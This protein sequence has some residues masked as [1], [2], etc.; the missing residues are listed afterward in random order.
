MLFEWCPVP[1]KPLVFAL[2]PRFPVLFSVYV[3]DAVQVGSE[4]KWNIFCSSPHMR[5]QLLNDP[6][7]SH[8]TEESA[9]R[10]MVQDE[11]AYVFLSGEGVEAVHQEEL[12]DLFVL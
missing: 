8:L 2:L 7:K 9:L 4:V 1:L 6:V 10:T 5:R 11:K 12:R 3:E